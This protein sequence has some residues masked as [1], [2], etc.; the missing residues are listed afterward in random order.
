MI[1]R[2]HCFNLKDEQLLTL[3]KGGK[4]EYTLGEFDG[5]HHVVNIYPPHYGVCLTVEEID[6]IRGMESK[7]LRRFLLNKLNSYNKI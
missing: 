5:K 4:L 6:S 1:T 3:I 7:E 2:Y